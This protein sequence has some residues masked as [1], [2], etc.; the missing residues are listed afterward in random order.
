LFECAR[1]ISLGCIALTV[2]WGVTAVFAV[3]SVSSAWAQSAP[4]PVARDAQR[5][6]DREQ[7]RLRARDGQLRDSQSTP[8]SG[9]EL[10]PQVQAAGDPGQCVSIRNVTVSGMTRFQQAGFSDVLGKLI[11]DCVSIVEINNALREI[12]NRYVTEGFVTSRAVVGPQ[13]LKDGALE[14]VIV[15]G[16]VSGIESPKGGYSTGALGSAFA[17]IKGKQLNLRAI[18]QGVDQLARLPSAEPDIDIA[19]AELPGASLLR[20]NRKKLDRSIRPSLSIDND[21]SNATGR[22]QATMSLDLDDVLNVADFWSL[23]YSRDLRTRKL[24]GSES[25]GGFASVPLGYWTFSLSGGR[26]SYR[27]IL[28]GN[29]QA[30]ANDGSSWNGSATVDR[31]L[32]RDARTK[33][34]AAGVLAILDTS[35]RIQG[36]RLSTSS[37]RQVTAAINLRVQRKMLGGLVG[38]DLGMT[39]GLSILGANAA[40]TGPGGATIKFS[41]INAGLTYQT[42]SKTLGI[43]V[44]YS[45]LLRAQA[46]L[47]PVFSSGRFGLGGSSTVRGFR[48]DGISGRYGLF[49]RHQVGFALPTVFK[50]NKTFETALRGFVGYDAG[51]IFSH[52]A[53]RFER[54]FMHASTIGIRVLGRHVQAEL[55]ASMPISAPSFVSRK[56]VELSASMR[57]IL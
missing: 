54:G 52:N 47:D 42:K 21:G 55:M 17:G 24:E 53:D 43:P 8:P 22:W 15:E 30:F 37:Y 40:D 32:F 12:T 50:S 10:Q 2:R 5:I 9:I 28:R 18:E 51:G 56:R 31:M 20:V 29:D 49:T 3:I 23:Y 34:S 14:I 45:A 57:F 38:G 36:I 48:D 19:P 44:D 13:N 16:Q 25:F 6:Q 39:R 33:V 27:S 1:K 7:E 11:G 4:D 41:K 35:N 26:Y 46:S